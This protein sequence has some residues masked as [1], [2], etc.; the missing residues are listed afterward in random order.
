MNGSVERRVREPE[1]K[2]FVDGESIKTLGAAARAFWGRPGVRK[3]AAS[4]LGGLALRAC[5]GPPGVADLKVALGVASF[6]PLQEWLAHKYL[7]HIRPFEVAGRRLD[8]GFARAHR[9]HHRNPRDI[10]Y[11]FL[12]EPVVNVAIPASAAMWVLG[13]RSMRG[14]ATGIAAYS[15]MALAYEWTHFLVHTGYKPSS[16]WFKRVRRNHRFHHYRNERYWYAFTVPHVDGLL[17]TEPDPKSVPVS[18]T[19]RNLHGLEG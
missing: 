8:P 1:R 7:L 9:A 12:P 4:A 17:G 5:L 15:A 10:D 18:N 2:D 16:A 13:A 14:A 3:M 19:A 11:T 6:W